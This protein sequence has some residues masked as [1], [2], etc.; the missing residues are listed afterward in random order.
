MALHG[1]A[2]LL[3]Q[4]G[5]SGYEIDQ[6]MVLDGSSDYLNWTAGTAT[7]SNRWTYSAWI[8]RSELGRDQSIFGA[9]SSASDA[10]YL[11]LWFRS[12]DKLQMGGTATNWRRTSQVFRDVGAYGHLVV[13]VDTDQ[14]TAGDRIK[15]Y[16]NGVQITSFGLENN[17]GSGNNIGVNV[18]GSHRIGRQHNAI[19]GANYYFNGYMS[20]INFVDGQQLEPT[21]FGEFY[22]GTTAWRPIEPSGLTYGTNGFYLPFTQD[23]PNLG[24]DYSGN[25]NDWTENG[26]PTQ[27]S[28]SPTVN[29]AT[30]NV[31][32]I[33]Q[34]GAIFSEGNLRVSTSTAAVQ[35][36]ASTIAFDASG[37]Y[38]AEFLVNAT[39]GT[40]RESI[41]IINTANFGDNNRAGGYGANEYCIRLDDGNK[42][43]NNSEVAYGDSYAATDVVGVRVDNGSL[44]FYKNGTIQNGGVPAYTGISGSC[45]FY[46]TID[47]GGTNP[48]ITA[49]F[50]STDWTIGTPPT[51][52]NDLSA[53]NL[54]EATIT[55][56]GE[57]F[58]AVAYTG[59]GT[60]IGSGGNSITGIG[61]QPDFTWIKNRDQADSHML[62]DVIRGATKVLHSNESAVE[63]TESETLTSFD[64]D[65]FTLGSD[66]EV[67]TNTE[68]YISWNWKAGGAGVV[69]T[70]GTISST[71]SVNDDAGFSLVTYG[72]N[73]TS[74]A[75]VGHGLSAA[76]EMMIIKPYDFAEAWQ[77]YHSYYGGTHR[78][79]ELSSTGAAAA[80]S[81]RWNNTDTTSSVFT[82]GNH[83]SVNSSS[84]NY[85]GLIF[86]SIPGYSK[87]FSYTGNG[88][89]DGTFVYLGFKP[90]WVIYK[91]S[92]STGA[93]EI[94][95]TERSGYNLVDDKLFA[96]ASTAETVADG[97]DILSNGF[98]FRSS[99][100]SRN[101]SGGTY[102]GIAFAENPFG[103]SNLPLGLAQ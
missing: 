53:A 12:D 9:G 30:F 52:A 91:R 40:N 83:A 78:A 100:A 73:S 38:Y 89:A 70:D 96:D 66:V 16:W 6:S 74:G 43:N 2:M 31:V 90:R 3:N 59:D 102:I 95:D 97:I 93:W 10:G 86:R 72:G 28:D 56:P 14:A 80:L 82:L 21:Y 84:Y 19:S 13:A 101:A 63:T 67:N 58:N 24:V 15:I 60:A 33:R 44:Y 69:N 76:P 18:A 79:G 41:G 42:Y 22:N 39:S 85:V 99:G 65:G 26:S 17:P 34:S 27:S 68:N 36:T 50:N 87:V 88:S 81:N 23:T 32:D 37:H 54:P 20:E 48:D 64:S 51:G 25:G 55:D 94:F 49:R 11:D 62:F 47:D 103:G 35:K 29:Y 92:D 61:F 5:Y 4:G 1:A 7:D 46:V 57:Y 71:V 98:K 77:V 8:K 75:T 45:R